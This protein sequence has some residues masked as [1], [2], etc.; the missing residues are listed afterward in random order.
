MKQWMLCA[1]VLVSACGGGAGVPANS[2]PQ[3][4][5]AAGR[6]V[7]TPGTL[8]TSAQQAVPAGDPNSEN[9]PAGPVAPK[10]PSAKLAA[11]C[12]RKAA[13]IRR[14]YG[15][16]LT[17]IVRPP[18]VV[19]GDMSEARLDSHAK[20][21]ILRPA[22]AMWTAYF[23]RKP[24]KVITTFL[25]A[26]EKNYKLHARK[27]YPSGG[28]PYYGYYTPA[29]RTMVMNI[30]T[31]TGTLVHELTHA[32]IVY[33]FPS[34]PTWF[35][36]G[37]ASLHE[38]CQVAEDGIKGLPN[39]RLP[40]LQAAIKAKKLRPLAELVT[41]RDF[42]GPRQGINYAQARYFVMYMQHK[43]LLVKFYRHFR[44]HST[45]DGAD[46]RAIEH[47]FGQKIPEIEPAFIKWVMTLK[48]RR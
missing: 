3:T 6:P 10:Y 30:N 47:I 28:T 22:R 7:R 11:L 33:D 38:Q 35:N 42:Y 16:K 40:A 32:L 29:R 44:E 18:F 26:G 20:W 48:F 23:D 12:G 19:A 2:S 15:E 46:V 36:E 37:L 14:E 8:D 43:G 27:D 5:P 17:V 34:V 4:Q 24:D 31:G 45:G 9:P 25:F 39:W 1:A 41:K 13:D 21:S